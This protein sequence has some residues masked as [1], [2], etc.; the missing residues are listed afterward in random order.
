MG[1]AVKTRITD[2]A[3]E[4]LRVAEPA[5]RIALVTLARPPANG[6]N[7]PMLDGFRTLAE[8]LAADDETRVAVITGEGKT[9]SVGADMAHF[10]S[11]FA[12]RA[13]SAPIFIR[14]AT[15]VGL[16]ALETLP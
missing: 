7:L 2:A 8:L 3:F 4:T 11:E 12:Q 6:V 5:P 13:E 15:K 1:T 9:F 14:L 16:L 10:Q